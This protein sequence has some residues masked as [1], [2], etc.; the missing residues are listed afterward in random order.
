MFPV[1]YAGDNGR[2]I[3]TAILTHTHTNAHNIYKYKHTVECIKY[4]E[5]HGF[6]AVCESF[7]KFWGCGILWRGTS[8]SFLPRKFPANISTHNLIQHQ[9][10]KQ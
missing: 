8:E 1:V 7:A 2:A 10:R 5:F 6:V 9:V 3:L 4:G